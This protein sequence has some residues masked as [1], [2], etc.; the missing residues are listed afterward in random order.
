MCSLA[1]RQEQIVQSLKGSCTARLVHERS[2][3]E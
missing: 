1:N 2:A 3:E